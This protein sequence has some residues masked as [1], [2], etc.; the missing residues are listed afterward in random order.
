MAFCGNCGTKVDEGVKF[1]PGC[2]NAMATPAAEQQTQTQ[3]PAVE[4]Q[5]TAQTQAPA[6]FEA[7]DIEN[8][9]IMAVLAYILFLIPLLAAKESPYAKFHTNQGLI[10]FIAGIAVSIV[11]SI[12]PLLGWFLI[13]P[14]G[15]LIVG[16]LGIMGIIN[17]LT[18]KAKE[19][20]VIGQFKLLK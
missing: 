8:N 4:K 6:A 10:L 19:L 15:G 12:I 20:P 18:G 3:S 11:G 2:G 13:L 9:K 1:C 17:A 16:I 7:K 14:V 5:A